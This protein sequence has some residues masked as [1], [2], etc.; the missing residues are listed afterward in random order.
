M[1]NHGSPV[2]LQSS[3]WLP[4]LY[5]SYSLAPRK[6]SPDTRVW[7]RPK[8]HIHRECGPRFPLMPHP[9]HNGLSSSPSRWRCLPRVL[10]PVR[11]PVTA[12]DW[13]LL[14]DR[15]LA[16]AP[17]IGPGISSRACLR[18]SPRPHHL[19]QC[20]LTNQWLSLFL[21]ISSRGSQ[22][23]LGSKKPQNT[24]APCELIGNLIT[25]RN[26]WN[27]QQGTQIEL[28]ING[29]Q[30]SSWTRWIKFWAL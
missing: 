29:R 18:V 24:A 11:R 14:K 30:K 9:L 16:L 28:E 20:W 6:R 26:R 25:S 3:R 27:H 19:A 22:G 8:P 1:S 2:T 13:V 10:C 4:N 12:L 23:R 21:Y 7:V 17:R 5:S 15:I